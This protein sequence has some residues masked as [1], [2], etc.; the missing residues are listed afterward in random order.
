[1]LSAHAQVGSGSLKGKVTDK[2]SGEALPFVSIVVENRGTQVS[3]G[4][5]DFDGLYN[6]KPIPPGVY[7]VVVSYV[8]YQSTKRTGVVISGNII[9]FLN[10]EMNTAGVELKDVE[11]IAYKVPL[12]QKDGGPSGTTVTRDQIAKMPGRSA[13]AIVTTVA[14]ATDAGTG[15]GVSIRG[16]RPENTYYYIDGVK[17][18]AG[19]GKGLPKGAIEEVQVITGGV[20]ANYGDVTGGL[21][22]ITTRGP[23]RAFFGGVEYLTS[24]FKTGKDIT[25]TRGLDR[26]GYNQLE[27]NLSGPLLFSKASVGNKTKPLIGFFLA[28]QYT[29]VVDCSPSYLGDVRV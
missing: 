2:K 29:N 5:T 3:G 1:M 11:V 17:V 23:S 27:A 10:I 21:V 18:S 19:A 28:G 25:S 9:T 16:G 8:G 14:G 24:G 20:P 6:I 15:G 26:Y 12:I 22:N 13:D 7:D 4:S